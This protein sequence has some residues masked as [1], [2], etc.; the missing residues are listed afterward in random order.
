MSLAFSQSPVIQFQTC[1]NTCITGSNNRLKK[2]DIG[3]QYLIIKAAPT[4]IPVI[5][6]P[7]GFVRNAVPTALITGITAPSA[8]LATE[9]MVFTLLNTP[10]IA[11][12][13]PFRNVK[14]YPS[15]N[16]A[17]LNDVM[18][19]TAKPIYFIRVGCF[20]AN[21]ANELAAWPNI[22]TTLFIAGNNVAPILVASTAI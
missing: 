16:D 18:P 6:N 10:T 21:S 4:A 20:S 3:F 5:I 13:P 7:T 12:A 9:N 22:P 17:N 19:A 11:S 15:A 1:L 14:P 2:A 8:I